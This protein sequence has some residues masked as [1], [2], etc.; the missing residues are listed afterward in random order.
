[1]KSFIKKANKRLIGHEMDNLKATRII[2]YEIF[3]RD[4]TENSA[5]FDLNKVSTQELSEL[6]SFLISTGY[7]KKYDRYGYF[8][9]GCINDQK[10]FIGGKSQFIVHYCKNFKDIPVC[11]QI[12]D[13]ASKNY[14]DQKL[15]LNSD[16]ATVDTAIDDFTKFFDGK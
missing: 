15:G 16:E 9:E 14:I 6:N 13:S 1:M 4:K 7:R 2:K 12:R 8:Y 5:F 11:Q 3:N 10:V